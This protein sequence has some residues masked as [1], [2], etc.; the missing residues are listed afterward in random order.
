MSF[1]KTTSNKSIYNMKTSKLFGLFAAVV[2]VLTAMGFSHSFSSVSAQSI[3]EDYYIGRAVINANFKANETPPLPQIRY[4]Q[5]GERGETATLGNTHYKLVNLVDPRF[6][7]GGIQAVFVAPIYKVDDG[8]EP[9]ACPSFFKSVG[10]ILA[11]CSIILANED[12]VAPPLSSPAELN[13]IKITRVSVAELEQFETLPYQTKTVDDPNLE[14]GKQKIEQEGKYG[15]KRLVYQVRRENGVEVSRTL[16][17][18]ETIEKPQNKI[19]KNG[20][21]VVVLSSVRGI[22]TATNLSNAVVSANYKRGTLLR[23]TNASN[24]VSILKTVNYTWGTADPPAGIVM[25]LSWSILD[26]LK[27]NGKGAGPSVLV[28]EIK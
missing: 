12:T 19:V 27:F 23:I 28:E 20:T 9:L 5:A 4:F 11:D 25:D 17:S 1:P 13:S 7:L 26:E 10:D 8:G 18:E 15:K 2:I 6:G 16:L 14:R 24:G 22:A 3:N 21:K